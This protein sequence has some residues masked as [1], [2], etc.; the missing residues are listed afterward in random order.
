MEK[1][2]CLRSDTITLPS[3]EMR[4]AMYQAEVGDDFYDCDPTVH[5]LEE[6]SAEILN[7]EASILVVSGTMGNLVSVLAQTRR[8]DSIILEE[9]SH[10]F[11]KEVG[12]VATVA[13]TFPR[14][15]KGVNGFISPKQLEKAVFSPEIL[16]PKSSLAC[17]ENSHNAAGG[18][19]LSVEETKS[20]CKVAHQNSL[21]VHLDGARLFNAA[22]AQGVSAAELVA[23]V[24]SATFCLTKGL[25]CP[26]GSI[27][28]GSREF[29]DEAR[30][31]RQMLGG[32]MRQ[33]GVFAAAGIVALNS[34]VD[35]IADDHRRAKLLAQSLAGAGMPLEQHPEDI[36]TNMVFVDFSEDK[37]DLNVF[38][39]SLKEEGVE[40]NSPNGRRLRFVTHCQIN[41]ED[42]RRAGD[43]I[44]QV[45][46]KTIHGTTS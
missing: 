22:V 41:D 5:Q 4:K 46:N 14:S 37:T 16:H 9:T 36:E 11:L 44:S 19:S 29:V 35:R 25:G 27:V 1:M 12:G 18:K 33:A 43:I 23:D 40:I 17:I 10:M 21:H 15:I 30:R 2:I 3:D 42:I 20:F 34:M 32:G 7:K 13:G 6:L 39:K 24:D 45:F 38:V 8:G 28:G 26:V 31:M